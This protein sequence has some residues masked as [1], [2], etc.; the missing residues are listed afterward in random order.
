MMCKIAIH[1][2]VEHSSAVTLL[3][4]GRMTGNAVLGTSN[5]GRNMQ[6]SYPNTMCFRIKIL[7]S[8]R[9]LSIVVL[10]LFYNTPYDSTRDIKSLGLCLSQNNLKYES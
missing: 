9:S 10:F 5:P 4:G 3:L 2:V 1:T 6:E 7:L 8:I